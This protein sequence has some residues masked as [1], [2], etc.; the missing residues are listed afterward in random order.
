MRHRNLLEK[1]LNNI[2]GILTALLHIVNTQSPI[3]SYKIN[4]GK[5]QNLVEEAKSLLESEPIG[6]GEHSNR[7]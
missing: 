7:Y 4:I 3:E 1:K 5:A 6:P 2:E